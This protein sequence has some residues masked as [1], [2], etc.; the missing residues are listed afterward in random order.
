MKI[1]KVLKISGKKK[2]KIKEAKYLEKTKGT[3]RTHSQPWVAPD[4]RLAEGF[5]F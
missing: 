1:K 4:P 3:K 5:P 2:R